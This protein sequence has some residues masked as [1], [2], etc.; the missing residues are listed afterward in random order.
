MGGERLMNTENALDET[1]GIDDEELTHRF[2]EAVRL[3]NE[4]SIVVGVPIARY[5]A[6]LKQPFFEYADG[7]REYAK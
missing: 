6:V 1:C 2:C 7:K 5:D 4:A 3:D